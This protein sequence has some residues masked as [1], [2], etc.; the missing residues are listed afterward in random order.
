M[1]PTITPLTSRLE[2]IMSQLPKE[3]Y[4]A[5]V[6]VG[7]VERVIEILNEIRDIASKIQC[8]ADNKGTCTKSGVCYSDCGGL[9]LEKHGDKIIISKYINN[10]FSIVL[11]PGKLEAK[12]KDARI[13]LE[14]GKLSFATIG[15]QGY[16]WDN[17]DLSNMEEVFNKNYSIKYIL[18]KIGKP[19]MQA[20]R[21]L[22]TC[23]TASAIVC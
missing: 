2:A 17:V 12:V 16:A 6:V 22:K 9:F 4:K 8:I 3:G 18:R 19:L 13:I 5:A 10:I 14:G 11:E 1:I 23:A 21:A 20:R 15:E 7:L